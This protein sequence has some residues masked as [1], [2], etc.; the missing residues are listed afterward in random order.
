MQELLYPLLSIE[1]EYQ[2]SLYGRQYDQTSIGPR[3]R[4]PKGCSSP[5]PLPPTR[6]VPVY[7]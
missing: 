6:R 5:S 7:C 3:I 2:D 1:K 4:S